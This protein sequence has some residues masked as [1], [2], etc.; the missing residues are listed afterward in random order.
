M[1]GVSAVGA[2]P[3]KPGQTPEQEPSKRNFCGGSEVIRRRTNRARER[4]SNPLGPDINRQRKE[5]RVSD[6][7]V[8]AAPSA[9]KPDSKK[10]GAPWDP[11]GFASPRDPGALASPRDPGGLARDA[12]TPGNRQLA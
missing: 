2:W 4:G 3:A 5:K 6:E 7:M 1:P 12:R 9:K 11:G 10:D 8:W